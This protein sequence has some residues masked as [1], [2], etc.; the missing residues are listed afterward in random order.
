M[1]VVMQAVGLRNAGLPPGCPAMFLPI[2]DEN[3]R[4][5]APIVTV[6]LIAVTLVVWFVVQGAG[7]DAQL[8]RSIC[9]LGMIPGELTGR[10]A[11]EV[12]PLGNGM[13]CVVGNHAG[14][15]TVLTSMFLHGDWL[16]LLGNLWFLWLFGDNVEDDLGHL[17]FAA[18][19]LVCVALGIAPELAL[20]LSACFALGSQLLSTSSQALWHRATI[21]Q[22]RLPGRLSEYQAG[23]RM[24]EK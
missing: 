23:V 17:P 13:A 4:R 6:G 5:T 18:F 11:G 20:L 15:H 21:S 22:P 10:A 7:G 16:H 3:P 24:S 14:W 1:A 9:E 2:H 19:Y 8:A 12:V